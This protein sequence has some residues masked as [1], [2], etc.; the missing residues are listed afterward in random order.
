VSTARE[1]FAH[2]SWR[3][4][5]G[6]G[7]YALA[8]LGLFLALSFPFERV[9]GA[10]IA[11]LARQM[12][13]RVTVESGGFRFPLGVGWRGVRI[14]PIAW[15]GP[16]LNLDVVRIRVALLP[17]VRRTIEAEVA[18]EA[19]GGRA[20]GASVVRLESGHAQWTV[21]Q[22][23]HGFDLSRLPFFPSGQWR[24]T[25]QL[26]LSDRWTDD[27][28]LAGEGAGSFEVAGLGIDGLTMAGFPVNGIEFDTVTGQIAFK[29]GTVAIRRVAA[30]GPLGTVAGD[31][32]LLVRTP[33]A[34]SVLNLTLTLNPTPGAASRVPL[35]ALAGASGGPMTVQIKGRLGSPDV[36]LNGTPIS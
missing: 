29:G 30:R 24:G 9:Q 35:L 34:E 3:V 12:H 28:W 1:R 21:D 14:E 32:T 18:W 6:Y 16:A 31:G 20:R 5:V 23:G 11:Q 17:L 27:A 13:S 33:W 2:S 8:A 10:L 19:Y 26:N 7:L 36:T 15:G 4:W 22:F 25:L